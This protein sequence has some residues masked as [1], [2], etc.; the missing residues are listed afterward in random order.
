MTY[1]VLLANKSY[2]LVDVR[3][4]K[5]PTSWKNLAPFYKG[6]CAAGDKWSANEGGRLSVRHCMWPD[7]ESSTLSLPY[8][9]DGAE[10]V[11]AG[12]PEPLAFPT[13]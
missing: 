2:A 11:Q 4:G 12:T 7:D 6:P 8:T 13:I 1:P 5:R 3:I 10:G 9:V